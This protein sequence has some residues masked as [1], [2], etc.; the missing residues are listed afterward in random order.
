MKKICPKN[1]RATYFFYYFVIKKLSKIKYD[2]YEFYLKIFILVLP[3]PE[4]LFER[5]E[6]KTNIRFRRF[7]F[8][9]IIY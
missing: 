3:F 2:I 8:R 6:K 4:S 7:K 9:A 1:N 5:C